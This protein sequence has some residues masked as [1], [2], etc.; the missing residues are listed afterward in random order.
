MAYG[1][2]ILIKTNVVELVELQPLELQP[3]KGTSMVL[4]TTIAST[5]FNTF[6]THN[7]SYCHECGPC[8]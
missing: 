6:Y 1:S 8:L 2:S 4:A 3:H 5:L 7:Y